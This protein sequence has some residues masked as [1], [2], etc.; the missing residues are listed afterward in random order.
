MYA[1]L[2]LASLYI[3]IIFEASNI[4]YEKTLYVT[5]VKLSMLYKT[6]MYFAAGGEPN[7]SGASVVVAGHSGAG[8]GGRAALAARASLLAGRRNTAATL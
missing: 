1:T 3:L 2:L 5:V 7:Y 8:A 6:I 4:Y